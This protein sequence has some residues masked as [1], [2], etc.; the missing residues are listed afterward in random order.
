[1]KIPATSVLIKEVPR[2]PIKAIPIE[3]TCLYADN[4]YGRDEDVFITA[5][6]IQNSIKN[7]EH[8]HLKRIN[9]FFSTADERNISG[10]GKFS[11]G[12]NLLGVFN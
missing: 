3:V 9:C 2:K 5:N 11:R 7:F 8:R 1:M 4:G 6:S 10:T 12:R